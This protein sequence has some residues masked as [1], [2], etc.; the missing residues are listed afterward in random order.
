MDN[1]WYSRICAILLMQNES[2]RVSTNYDR[3]CPD[4]LSY[5]VSTFL[6]DAQERYVHHISAM[7]FEHS[8]VSAGGTK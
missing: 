8:N 6:F 1:E 2:C 4:T 5:L 7:K 3:S